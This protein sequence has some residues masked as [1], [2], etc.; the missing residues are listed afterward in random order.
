MTM[1]VDDTTV[2]DMAVVAFNDII[3]IALWTEEVM[4]C[5]VWLYEEAGGRSAVIR[6]AMIRN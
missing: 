1:N 3:R 4:V 6:S 2:Q 5:T